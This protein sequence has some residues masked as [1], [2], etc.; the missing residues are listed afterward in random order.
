MT[1][2]SGSPFSQESSAKTDASSLYNLELIYAGGFRPKNL[3]P[4]ALQPVLFTNAWPR[5]FR[6]CAASSP[7]TTVALDQ[8]CPALNLNV[9]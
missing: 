4:Q 5:C 2:F 7:I 1:T 8:S 9:V 6:S 3:P